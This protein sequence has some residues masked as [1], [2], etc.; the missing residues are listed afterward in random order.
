LEGCAA[1]RAAQKERRRQSGARR[2]VGRRF[3]VLII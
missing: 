2:E 3:V 1:A